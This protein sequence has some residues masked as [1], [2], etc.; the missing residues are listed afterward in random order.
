MSKFNNKSKNGP[1][2]NR[3]FEKEYIE[4]FPES[5]CMPLQQWKREGDML[6][7]FTLLEETPTYST[8]DTIIYQ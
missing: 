4:L 7:Q 6:I 2:K 5:P 3:D 8:S 1:V